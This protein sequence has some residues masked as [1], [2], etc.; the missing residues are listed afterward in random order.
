MWLPAFVVFLICSLFT[1]LVARQYLHSKKQSHLFWM[2]SLGFSALASLAYGLTLWTTPHSGVLFVLYYVFGALWMPAIMGLGSLALVF[3]KR[4]VY[5]IAAIVG[6]VGLTGTVFLA[7]APMQSAA[8]QSL[9]GGAGVNVI[10]NGAWLIELI[11]LNT[12]GGAAVILVALYS[13]WKTVRKQSSPRFL[14]GNLWL[15]AGVLVISSAG[16]MARLGWP[17]TFWFVMLAGWV[18]TFV[19]Y[20]LLT[21]IVRSLERGAKPQPVPH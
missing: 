18:I 2:V 10:A 19:G 15:A 12:F 7:L 3:S 16:A 13:A 6:I 4:T 11:S 9:N 20:R 14:H 5:V 17:G 1:Y 8:L 21:P